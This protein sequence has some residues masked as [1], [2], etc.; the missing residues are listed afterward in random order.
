MSTYQTCKDKPKR[1]QAAQP[2]PEP[3]D[4]TNG[5]QV[6]QHLEM[7]IPPRVN[8]G[9]ELPEITSR[10]LNSIVGLCPI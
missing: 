2:D 5:V 10:P 7:G 3:D 9:A 8:I 4:V 1:V 6:P